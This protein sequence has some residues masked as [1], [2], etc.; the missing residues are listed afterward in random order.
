MGKTA[1]GWRYFLTTF[2]YFPNV[3]FPPPP[4]WYKAVVKLL[5]EARPSRRINTSGLPER[6]ARPPPPP[7]ETLFFVRAR[8]AK[9]KV[10][11]GTTRTVGR[12]CC[13]PSSSGVVV[14]AGF[15]LVTLVGW[16]TT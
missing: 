8:H 11:G 2:R 6:V 1:I 13:E 14:G 3:V 12:R 7:P 15:S 4:C 9:I 5:L 10:A 16:Q